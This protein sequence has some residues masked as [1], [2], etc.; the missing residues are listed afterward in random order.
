MRIKVFFDETSCAYLIGSNCRAME[1]TGFLLSLSGPVLFLGY[2]QRLTG[3]D[4]D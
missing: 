3:N 2:R 4:T 1:R